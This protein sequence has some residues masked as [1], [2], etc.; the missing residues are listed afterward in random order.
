MQG[1]KKKPAFKSSAAIKGEHARIYDTAKQ[2]LIFFVACFAAAYLV[3][4]IRVVDLALTRDV[5][6]ISKTVFKS[7]NKESFNGMRADIVDRNGD[8]MASTLKM[9]SVYADTS[10]IEDPEKLAAQIM[11]VLPDLD[12]KNLVDNLKS[13]RKFVWIKRNITPRQ[14]YALN[15]IGEPA[16]SFKEENHRV[17]PNNNLTAHI[18][19]YTDVDGN[20][21]SGIENYFDEKIKNSEENLQLSIDLKVQHAMRSE[22]MEAMEGFKAK[23]A[24]GM[25]MNVNT[26]EIIS[27]VSL[28]DFDPNNI[29]NASD[30][31]KFNRATL[32]VFEMGSTFK[33][34]STAAALDSN[35]V[36]FATAFDIREPIKSGKYDISDFHSKKRPLTVPEIFIYSS[37]VGTAKMAQLLGNEKVEN[38]YRSMGF[39]DKVP[40]TEIPEKG[41]PLYPSPWRDINTL[42]VSF[43]HGIAVS[44]LHLIRAASALVNGGIMPRATIVKLKDNGT[45]DTGLVMEANRVV[46]EETSKKL[47]Q[48]LE[49]VVVGGTG[50]NAYVKGYSVGGKT[51]TAEKNINGEYKKDILFSSFIGMFPMDKPEYA[52]LAILDEP[53][54]N[55]LTQGNSA[56]G[57]Y[58]AAPVVAKVV[59]HIGS[60]YQIAPE[61]GDFYKTVE[62]ELKPYLKDFKEGA[63][64][65]SVGT[66][67]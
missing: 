20:G 62:K 65:V 57:G 54:P 46:S 12:L 15:A 51:G 48:L 5:S 7:R 16:I 53:Q 41:Y 45:D 64:L 67:R 34:F 66:D 9:S 27:M 29:G 18:I 33:L 17:Y 63:Q 49:L 2:R 22:L 52:I 39:L 60:I 47:R 25:V 28:P 40:D 13:G 50:N 23:A 1:V 59:K 55:E 38:F 56:T 24:I 36:S 21:I 42:T 58:A 10:I 30:D 31:E 4:F 61:K 26:G 35:K 32:G 14:K 43:G 37:N 3:V 8:L 19:G 44:P 6:E 11:E